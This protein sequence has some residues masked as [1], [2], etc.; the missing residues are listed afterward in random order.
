MF[1]ISW[2]RDISCART[3][4]HTFSWSSCLFASLPLLQPWIHSFLHSFSKYL[5]VPDHQA[6]KLQCEAE[7]IRPVLLGAPRQANRM[8]IPWMGDITGKGRVLGGRAERGSDR[9]EISH[10]VGNSPVNNNNKKA[11]PVGSVFGYREKDKGGPGRAR[12]PWKGC[13]LL[14]LHPPVCSLGILKSQLWKAGRALSHSAPFIQWTMSQSHRVKSEREK[15][16]SYINAYMWNLEKWYWRSCLQNRN[17]DTD[18]WTPRRECGR[19]KLG[20]RG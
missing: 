19:D 8:V 11:C 13:A 16:M 1:T 12:Q 6:W 3:W 20:H 15:Q 9:K 14:L 4:N 10:W 2:A 7:Q 17:R 5:L 18:I